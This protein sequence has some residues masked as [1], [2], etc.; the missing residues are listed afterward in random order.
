MGIRDW[1]NARDARRLERGGQHPD[2]IERTYWTARDQSKD[3]AR[4][5]ALGYTPASERDEQ[6]VE[7]VTM[8][9]DTGG[10]TGHLDK[11]VSRRVPLAFV[12]YRRERPAG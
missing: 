2:T 10:V 12:T 7:E 11:T 8:L 5:A 9:A 3:A 6:P 1:F 4:L